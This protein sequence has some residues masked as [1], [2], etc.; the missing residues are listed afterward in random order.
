MTPYVSVEPQIIIT[1]L[2][3]IQ[4]SNPWG[5]KLICTGIKLKTCLKFVENQNKKFFL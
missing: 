1:T 5:H 2:G 4:Y 3:H